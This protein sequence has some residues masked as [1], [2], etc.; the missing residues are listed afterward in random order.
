MSETIRLPDLMLVTGV[1]RIDVL[2]ARLA[3]SPCLQRGGLPWVAHFNCDSAAK[4]FNATLDSRPRA[5][6]LVW[7]HQDVF[8]PDGS[9]PLCATRNSNFRIW[10]WPVSMGSAARDAA[11]C[12]Q[13]MCSIGDSC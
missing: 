2:S 6:W 12:G 3:A 11:L 4:A 10:P 7:V 5:D 1:S 8:L 13:G 9:R